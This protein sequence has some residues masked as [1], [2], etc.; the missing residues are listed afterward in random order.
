MRATSS[1]P[2]AHPRTARL[3]SRV[4]PYSGADGASYLMPAASKPASTAA[5][6][7]SICSLRQLAE[8]RPRRQ[9][10]ATPA[11]GECRLARELLRQRD[12]EHRREFGRL[13]DES[14]PWVADITL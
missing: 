6:R 11:V 2:P 5:T 1:V 8:Q 14:R 13:E 10:H 4:G 12:I 9:H 3:A 7:A